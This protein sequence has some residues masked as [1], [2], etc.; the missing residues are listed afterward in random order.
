MCSGLSRTASRPPWI[1]GCRVLTRPSSISGKPVCDETSVTAT[2]DFS[3]RR[4]VP[5]VERIF[6]P[7]ATRA[8]ANSTQPDL[9]E[10]LIS[11]WRTRF[12]SLG[13][14]AQL[15]HLLAQR[16]AV[17]AEHRGRERLVAFG[18]AEH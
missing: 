2:P 12:I 9:S 13:L 1:F 6:T 14:D 5:P 8:C 10:T 16:I 4:A 17:D 3:S 15:V 18:V 11:A 7:S